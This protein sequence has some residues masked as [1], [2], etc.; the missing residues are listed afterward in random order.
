MTDYR[1][2]SPTLALQDLRGSVSMLRGL[3]DLFLS[4]CHAALERTARAQADGDIPSLLREV[5]TLRGSFAVLRA[6][7]ARRLA[8]EIHRAIDDGSPPTRERL[9]DLLAEAVLLVA[10]LRAWRSESET[11]AAGD[12][13]PD[14]S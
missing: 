7:P 4:D 5:H 9:D 14:P 3:I 1:S 8:G 2:F 11:G 12:V 6:E 13:P 10:E